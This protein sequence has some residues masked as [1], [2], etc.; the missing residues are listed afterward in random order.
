M[1][2]IFDTVQYMWYNMYNKSERSEHN[3][4]SVKLFTLKQP[5]QI[6]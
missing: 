2:N 1:V 3:K 4:T 6:L 5:K